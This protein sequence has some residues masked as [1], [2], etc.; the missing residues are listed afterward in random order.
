MK[1][2]Q[3]T[4]PSH[5][6]LLSKGGDWRKK[7]GKRMTDA[8]PQALAHGRRSFRKIFIKSSRQDIQIN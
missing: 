2:S 3:Y 5:P 1:R 6:A 4:D 8:L 7:R